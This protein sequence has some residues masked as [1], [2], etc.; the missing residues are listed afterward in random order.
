[1]DLEASL[2]SLEQ[3][4]SAVEQQLLVP[5]PPAEAT[6]AEQSAEPLAPPQ[7]P[8]QPDPTLAGSDAGPVKTVA[9]ANL[10]M[11]QMAESKFGQW[12][13]GLVFNGAFNSGLFLAGAPASTIGKSAGLLGLFNVAHGVWNLIVE[14]SKPK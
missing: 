13:F 14:V 6:P 12:L 4:V 8:D 3:R 5:A 11:I 2:R 9:S 1:M 10:S 7:E